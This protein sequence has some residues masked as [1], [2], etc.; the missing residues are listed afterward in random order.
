[1]EMITIRDDYIKLGQALK[2]AGLVESGVDAKMEIQEGFVKVNGEVELQRGKKIYNGDVIE[3]EGKQ[4]MV[5][6][7]LLK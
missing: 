3:Y 6:S 1:M 5:K 7:G 2:L 4:I